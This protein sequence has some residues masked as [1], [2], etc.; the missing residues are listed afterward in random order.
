VTVFL[1]T[2]VFPDVTVAPRFTQS[3]IVPIPE[4]PVWA[5]GGLGFV[6]GIFFARR[7][8]C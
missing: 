2:G 7:C 1:T 3:A 5:L 6:V 4:P 8:R